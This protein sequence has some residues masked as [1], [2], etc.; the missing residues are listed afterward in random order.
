[1]EMEPSHKAALKSWRDKPEPGIK[2][3]HALTAY[4]G[5]S[6]EKGR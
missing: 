5:M 2:T 3:G 4:F 1:M 6:E